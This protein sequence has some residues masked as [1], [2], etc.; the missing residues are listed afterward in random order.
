[1][2]T[3]KNNLKTFASKMMIWKLID[4]AEQSGTIS[5]HNFEIVDVF[6]I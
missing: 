2:K 6:Y 4:E 5:V 1:M 3:Q